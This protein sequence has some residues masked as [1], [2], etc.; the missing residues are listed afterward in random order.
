MRAAMFNGPGRPITIETLAEPQPGPDELLVRVCRCGI[1]GSDVSM[2]SGGPASLPLGR[3]GHEWAGEILEV[4]RDVGNDG[5]RI[6]ALPV[7]R[8][9]TCEGCRTGNPLFCENAG[10]LVGGF[11]EIWSFPSRRRFRCRNR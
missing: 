2:S 5:A 8:C 6:A 11:G 7:P 1:C 9:G 4:G 3:F 10:Y